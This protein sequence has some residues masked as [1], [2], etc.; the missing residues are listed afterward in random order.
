LTAIFLTNNASNIIA[1][2]YPTP[3]GTVGLNPFY[4]TGTI[5]NAPSAQITATIFQNGEELYLPLTATGTKTWSIYL[6]S[7]RAGQYTVVAQ[8]VDPAGDSSV[9][10]ENFTVA[11]NGMLRLS[12]A[13]GGTAG[14][15]TNGESLMLGTNFT[16]TATPGVGEAFYNWS[17]GAHLY[18]NTS[19]SFTMSY[20]LSLTAT[21]IATNTIKGLTFTYPPANGYLRTN[22]FV[23]KGKIAT[24][25]KSAS[26]TCQ[27]FQT[28]GLAVGPPMTTTGT[29]NWSI[30]VTNLPGG[31]YLVQAVATNEAG[32]TTVVSEKFSVYA[33]S[34]VQG[35]Y[36][37]LFL[38]TNQPVN[39]TN[40]GF[41]TF[42]VSPYGVMTGKLEF[43][44]YAMVPIYPL[45]FFNSGFTTGYA[46]FGTTEFHGAPLLATIFM[47]LSGDSDTAYGSIVSS[48]NG[49]SS[50]LLCYRTLPKLSVETM[51][52]L[53]K[54]VI[55]L[56]P[57]NQTNAAGA[58]GFAS[59][60]VSKNGK[61]A[62]SGMLPDD[63]KFSQSVG[64]SRE[65]IWPLYAV[66]T[67]V[68]TNG[69][70]LGWETFTNDGSCSGQ[71]YWYKGAKLGGYYTN[72][73][74]LATNFLFSS[75]GSNYLAPTVN[76]PYSIVFVGGALAA[77]LTNTLTVAKS[78]QF[79]VPKGTADK[80]K[81]SLTP[82]GVLTG[83]FVNP[84]GNKTVHFSGAFFNPVQGGS[85]F[86]ADVDGQTGVFTI[87]PTSP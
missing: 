38:C 18:F 55:S 44:G 78:G 12:V 61:L 84:N 37:G 26:I 58:N 57:T 39:A 29:N 20:G 47:D 24:T 48:S 73:V 56:Q 1:F 76:T 59:V 68:K 74:G 40:S 54:Y 3:N 19:Q 22:A 49:W 10:Q 41:F 66:P 82:N 9:I 14:P 6:G 8:G 33:F 65:G 79:T 35:T 27:F 5:S 63:T 62:V 32:K 4:L 70:V 15:Y 71:L 43:P 46:Q 21:F 2:T 80:L 85:G 36:A 50:E 30:D 60:L 83:T 53:G 28:N 16:L 64:V 75:P 42:T 69:A 51:P 11:T 72:G 81:I 7:L 31:N 86:V 13:G 45:A 52:A 17:D 67:G 25:M 23:L 34:A 87:A 77:P